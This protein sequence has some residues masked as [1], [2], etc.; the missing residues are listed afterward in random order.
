MISNWAVNTLLSY[1]KGGQIKVFLEGYAF[2]S[3]G[4]VFQIAENTG[5]LKNKLDI[6]G[7]EFQTVAPQAIKKFATGKGNSS[8]TVVYESFVK[9]TSED[10]LKNFQLSNPEASPINDIA[11]SYFICKYG[12]NVLTG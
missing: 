3:K 2:A 10:L 5:V 7:I 6:Q 9:E 1:S 8:K 11:D 12:F 4:L